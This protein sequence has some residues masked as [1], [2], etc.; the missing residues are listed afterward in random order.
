MSRQ[1]RT[2]VWLVACGVFTG[3]CN[4]DGR[5][6]EDT[7]RL[8]ME[9]DLLS[10]DIPNATGRAFLELEERRPRS[11]GSQSA[12]DVLFNVRVTSD[13]REVTA[14]HIH[15][16]SEV[17][18]AAPLYTFP[19]ESPVGPGVVTNTFVTRPYVGILPFATLV[20]TL[21]ATPVI[22][23]VHTT[24]ASAP[25]LRG[26]ARVIARDWTTRYCDT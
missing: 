11:G 25:A 10:V 14:V 23:D 3:A 8:T 4:L 5:C 9:A 26:S 1:L 24:S 19:L 12:Q 15:R 2:L 16:A 18:H 22:V 13:P 17:A 6:R 7:R 20:S 21:A